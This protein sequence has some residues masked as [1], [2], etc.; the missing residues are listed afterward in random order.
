MENYKLT[1]KQPYDSSIKHVEKSIK[2][3]EGLQLSITQ[4][5]VI[6]KDKLEFLTNAEPHIEELLKQITEDEEI[7]S[8]CWLHCNMSKVSNVTSLFKP[9][10]YVK[11]IDSYDGKLNLEITLPINEEGKYRIINVVI[12]SVEELKTILNC[13]K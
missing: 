9:H 13:I 2:E 10:T 12:N 7:I 8:K 4:D 11:R 5:L 3:L 6:W 1:E